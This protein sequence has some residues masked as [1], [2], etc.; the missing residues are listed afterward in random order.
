MN[1]FVDSY[2]VLG[3]ALLLV[4]EL[5]FLFILVLTLLF[6]FGF[7]F[8]LVLGLAF[9]VLLAV[10]RGGLFNPLGLAF[11][12]AVS[13]RGGAAS[14]HQQGDLQQ[15]STRWRRHFLNTSWIMSL[16]QK[17]KQISLLK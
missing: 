4:F 16:P 7:T 15:Q 11:G 3:L 6:V 12:G 10:V 2:L 1:K 14:R 8:L 9:L 13:L 5:A 17:L